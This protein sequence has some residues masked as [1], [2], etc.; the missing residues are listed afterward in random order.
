MTDTENREAIKISM[1]VFMPEKETKGSNKT[2]RNYSPGNLDVHVCAC[3]HPHIHARI[4]K[5]T[6][7]NLYLHSNKQ[8]KKIP[9]FS[10]MQTLSVYVRN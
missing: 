10:E 8:M 3:T 5:H 1:T 9:Y 6:R 7:T 4:R 2:I